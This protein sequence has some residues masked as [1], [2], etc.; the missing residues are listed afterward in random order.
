[1]SVTQTSCHGREHWIVVLVGNHLIDAVSESTLAAESVAALLHADLISI[2]TLCGVS[3]ALA[4]IPANHW[5]KAGLLACFPPVCI[6]KHC[7]SVLSVIE[8]ESVG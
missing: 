2:K 7:L 1:M 3:A 6:C 8:P 4:H 5:S